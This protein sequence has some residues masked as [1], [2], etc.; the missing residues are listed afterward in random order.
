VRRHLADW[1]IVLCAAPAYLERRGM[2][3][4]P[5][6][7]ASHDFLSLPSGHHPRDVLFGPR[8]QTHR[9]TFAPRVTSNDQFAIRQLA[10]RGAGLSFQAEPEIAHDLDAGRLVRVLPRWKGHDVSV[11]ALMPARSPQ[12][13]KV[14][15]AVDALRAHL[16]RPASSR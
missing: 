5:A 1:S 2:P 3:R 10:L 6:E 7:L 14:R 9:V 13:A 8:G 4:T 11:D 16:G 15:I 12:P